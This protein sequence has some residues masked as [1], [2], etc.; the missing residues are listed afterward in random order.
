MP[1]TSAAAADDD[2]TQFFREGTLARW[3]LVPYGDLRLRW[4][5]VSG[6]PGLSEVFERQ[7]ATLR[8][9]LGWAPAA[10]GIEA[11]LG[12]R[13]GLGSETRAESRAAF[14]NEL[15]DTVEL[16]RAALR[17]ATAGGETIVAG[18]APL[19]LALTE[20]LWDPDLRPV[21]VSATATLEN[22][23]V[24]WARAAAA[25]VMRSRFDGDDGRFA[26]GQIAAGGGASTRFEVVASYVE[27]HHLDELARSALGRQNAVVAGRY[28]S[29]F[30][31]VDLQA[32]VELLAGPVPLAAR[33]EVA[34]NTARRQDR[35]AVRMR[36]AAGGPE[37]PAGLEA[38]WVYQRIEREAVCGAFN[39]DDWWFHSR[40]RGHRL[41]LAGS[42][43]EIDLRASALIERRDDR[44][45]DTRR[46]LVELTAR[47]PE[48]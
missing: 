33:A 18:K 25:W 43:R 46:W 26:A 17:L 32:G 9:G 4:D 28:A 20:L 40:A 10:M 22:V 47:L 29:R 38:G 16:D 34:R 44:A 31:V 13:A 19:P 7:R 41:W 1:S 3:S 23:G 30:R 45:H 36:I 39:S 15:P 24:P 21:G 12:A 35:D 37:L 14:D 42:W 8:A 2:T 11:W 27:P 6:R 5:R 48:P